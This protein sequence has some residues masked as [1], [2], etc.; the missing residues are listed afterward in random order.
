[1]CSQFKHGESMCI[2]CCGSDGEASFV[3]GWTLQNQGGLE[4]L[5]LPFHSQPRR[6]MSR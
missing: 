2:C 1:M 6:D 5:A 3:E 4:L